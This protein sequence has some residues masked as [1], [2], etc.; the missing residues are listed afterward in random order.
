[1]RWTASSTVVAT[2]LLAAPRAPA[3]QR[4]QAAQADPQ[5]FYPYP[6]VYVF[7]E[8]T[9]V[10]DPKASV[11]P[12][13]P[14]LRLMFGARMG[15][16]SFAPNP[17]GVYVG[18][19]RVELSR[20]PDGFAGS[21]TWEDTGGRT[22]HSP[23]FVQR[24]DTSLHCK[25]V[26][27]NVLLGLAM[28]FGL[29]E[30]DLGTKYARKT[31]PPY[32]PAPPQLPGAP[33]AEVSACP[34]ASRFE[35]WPTESPLS[36][37]RAPEPDPPKPRESL[38]WLR[39]G[40]G[41]W[42]DYISNDRGSLGL[43]LDASVRR[44]WFSIMAEGRG[45]PPLGTTLIPTGAGVRFARVTGALLLCGHVDPLVACLKAQAGAV[46]FPG[47]MPPVAAQLYTA[48]GVRVGLEFPV[49]PWFLVRLDGEVLPTIA[50]ASAFIYNQSVLQVA[51]W[52]AGLGLSG[53]FA[54]GRP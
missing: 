42:V 36:P 43:T 23:R 21:Y 25:E 35:R 46:L 52:N 34:T 45:N 26:L 2:L 40:A 4:P 19:V 47:T 28:H 49:K 29:I 9:F 13:E 12:D 51:G 24:G 5:V 6:R 16:D 10:R 20:T 31:P 7:A 30:M 37:L 18:R 32:C 41:V 14:L 1:M 22:D 38:F 3:Q 17:R 8:L 11:C 15:I 44:G 39:F 50:P 54:M 48:V 53:M 27:E 33:P